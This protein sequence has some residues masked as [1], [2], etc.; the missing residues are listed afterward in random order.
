MFFGV[1]GRFPP[2]NFLE[3]I[4][5]TLSVATGQILEKMVKNEMSFAKKKL[6]ITSWMILSFRKTRFPQYKNLYVCIVRD[7]ILNFPKIART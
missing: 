2:H 1:T 7:L 6:T 5:K 4:P 3:I